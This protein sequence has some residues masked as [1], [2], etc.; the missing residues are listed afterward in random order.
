MYKNAHATIIIIIFFTSTH[1]SIYLLY[2]WLHWVFG[3]ACR[4]SLAAEN[5]GYTS[6]CCVGSSLQWLILWSKAH[7]LQQLQHSGSAV[8]AC[9]LWGMQ[10]SA[11]V[12]RGP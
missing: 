5:G 3:A 9:W 12:V 1:G 2:F 10:A 4:L 6:L 8:V 11:V 7:R